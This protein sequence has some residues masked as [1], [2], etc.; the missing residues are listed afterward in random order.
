MPPHDQ[1]VDIL[2]KI[3]Y[4][5]NVFE[6]LDKAAVD[7]EKFAMFFRMPNVLILYSAWH[8]LQRF[9]TNDCEDPDHKAFGNLIKWLILKMLTDPVWFSYLG[10]FMWFISVHANP[11]SYYPLMMH[12]RFIPGKWY[13]RGEEVDVVKEQ[14]EN[15]HRPDDAFTKVFRRQQL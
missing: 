2:S 7:Q 14:S 13:T 10:H 4:D 12:D 3:N 6:D 5:T 15:C 11:S 9:D 8:V 1:L